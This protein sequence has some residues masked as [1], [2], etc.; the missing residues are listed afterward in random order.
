[1]DYVFLFL[2]V[3]CF[4]AQFAFT[5]RFE[6][7]AGQ[8]KTGSLIML[9]VTNG[10]GFL[11]F[12]MAGGFRLEFTP[13]ATVLALALSIIMIPYYMLGIRVLSLGSLAVYSMFMMLG[14]MLVPFF[15][16]LLFLGESL[17]WGQGPGYCAAVSMH[18][19]AGIDS[20][21]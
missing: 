15:Y 8:S 14:G 17:T 13:V 3:V 10:L 21:K 6:Q 11:L 4:T 12:F 2:A 19:F 7:A 20:T 18:C 16:G 1:M 9:V 5:K